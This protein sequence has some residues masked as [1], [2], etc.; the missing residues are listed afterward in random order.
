MVTYPCRSNTVLNIAI[1]HDTN[2]SPTDSPD[3][4]WSWQT[5]SSKTEVLQRLQNFH[6]DIKALVELAS[7][8]D[9]KVH[10]GMHRPPLENFVRGKA[11]M[12][13]DSAHLMMPT[14]AAGAS[15]AI[16]SAAVLEVLMRSVSKAESSFPPTPRMQAARLESVRSQSVSP[17]PNFDSTS[18]STQDLIIGTEQT[19]I[20]ASKDGTSLNGVA[21]L[22]APEIRNHPHQGQ[23]LE[24]PAD[25]SCSL[26]PSLVS[27]SLTIFDSLRV[28]RCTAF[29]L[30]SNGGF[31][32]QN[33]PAVVEQI[34]RH[35]FDGW[36]PGPQAGPWTE[37]YLKWYFEYDAVLDAENV[38]AQ[39][40]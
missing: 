13:G 22:L 3:A 35:G 28:P 37:E 33:D 34:R 21:R 16:E 12:M 32:S 23:T 15:M 19:S 1:V 26:I 40:S 2:L 5:P 25:M 39:L 24:V 6:P 38:V 11:L 27:R 14:H 4:K 18:S 31:L 30:L 9:I 36:L 29:Q 8:D 17:A 10:H 20:H 7:D